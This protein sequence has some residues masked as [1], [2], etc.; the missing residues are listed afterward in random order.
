VLAMFVKCDCGVTVRNDDVDALVAE[1]QQH[2]VES[3]WTEV[4]REDVLEMIEEDAN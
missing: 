3:H 4:E 1:V 2:V